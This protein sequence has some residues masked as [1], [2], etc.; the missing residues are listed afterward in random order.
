MTV[1]VSQVVFIGPVCTGKTT[2]LRLVADRVGV[3][4]VDLDEVANL[5]YEEVGRGYDALQVKG[6]EV[7]FLASYRWWREGH[8][9][10]VRRVFEDHPQA[11]VAL[12]AGHTHYQDQHMFDVVATVLLHRYPILV[13]PSSDLDQ[14][15]EVIRAR[16]VASRDM[17]WR[18]GDVD[19]IERWVKRP[20]QPRPRPLDRLH[21]E[22]DTASDGRR[23]HGPPGWT[24]RT[25]HVG[26]DPAHRLGWC[27]TAPGWVIWTRLVDE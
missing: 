19:F 10:A 12:G 11:V 6:D 21:G 15:V 3:E 18:Y 27:L 8:P 17:D 14:S 25:Q 4:V 2:L 20:R 9:H 24:S 22:P 16:S 1:A 7:G 26:A 23:D 5:Y 13:L